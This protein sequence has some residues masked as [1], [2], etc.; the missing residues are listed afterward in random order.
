MSPL[1]AESSSARIV[2]PGT[3]ASGQI[4]PESDLW[5]FDGTL[6][7]WFPHPRFIFITDTSFNCDTF[8]EKWACAAQVFTRYRN[9]KISLKVKLWQLRVRMLAEWRSSKEWHPCLSYLVGILNWTNRSNVNGFPL[10]PILS[11]CP[12]P[13]I[14]RLEATGIPTNAHMHPRAYIRHHRNV[15]SLFAYIIGARVLFC[16]QARGGT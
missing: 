8:H 11:G 13:S 2:K 6:R 4:C 15:T 3:W 5:R 14:A 1:G 10:Y 16:I 9:K 12:P 7:D